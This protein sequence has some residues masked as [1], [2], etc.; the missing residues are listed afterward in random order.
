MPAESS[1]G[2]S[3]GFPGDVLALQRMVGN[4]AVARALERE[5]RVHGS[6]RVSGAPDERGAAVQDVTNSG[7]RPIREPLRAEMEARLG[8]PLS[9]VRLHTGPE[10]QRS[11]AA[12]GARAYTSGSHIVIGEGGADKQ[13][14]VHELI[15]VLQ[16]REGPVA[17]SDHGG[18]VR[19]SD[20]S[21]RFERAAETGAALVMSAPVPHMGTAESLPA[22]TSPRSTP[23][24][25]YVVQRVLDGDRIE[26]WRE[27][28]GTAE[29]PMIVEVPEGMPANKPFKE[30]PKE[31]IHYL[32]PDLL[33]LSI[34]I[35]T[36]TGG[37]SATEIV[38]SAGGGAYFNE[39]KIL[40]VNSR[41][42][43]GFTKEQTVM[44]ELGHWQQNS[45]GLDV[46]QQ[47]NNKALVEYHNILR[48]EN[49]LTYAEHQE[50]AQRGDA[51]PYGI[52]KEYTGEDKT[53]SSSVRERMKSEGLAVVDLWQAL[54][55][56][57]EK[58]GNENEKR[59]LREIVEELAQNRPEYDEEVGSKFNRKR[60]RVL[61]QENI[62]RA[63]FNDWFKKKQSH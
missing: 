38:D 13:T 59:L 62:A 39:H 23:D 28:L 16:Q 12:L 27:R 54:I 22:A 31:S 34:E 63:Y 33:G 21:D 50:M 14:L 19:L 56:S 49:K 26:K 15:H 42:S 46:D 35:I 7:G 45:V 47:A 29:M 61:I 44:H 36:R 1:G 57:V 5:R 2:G 11:A 37:E 3:G 51:P 40:V 9:D 20:P 17:G 58:T 4:A 48:N 52:R 30:Y 60:V 41:P 25:G 24:T 55:E 32:N 6:K 53:I 10:A 8:A 43:G 18:G